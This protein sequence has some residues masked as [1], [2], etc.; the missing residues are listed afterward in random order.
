VASEVYLQYSTDLATWYDVGAAA[1]WNYA[2]GQATSGDTLTT[3]KL[4]TGVTRGKYHESAEL[5][6]AW[7]A[8]SVQEVDFA[9][10]PVE[11]NVLR[12]ILYYFRMQ[13]NDLDVYTLHP[14]DTYPSIKLP[15]SV[16]HT[17][18]LADGFKLADTILSKTIYHNIWSDGFDPVSPSWGTACFL[19]AAAVW[20]KS[21]FLTAEAAWGKSC[22]DTAG[23][24]WTDG[25]ASNV[26]S[27]AFDKSCW[28]TAGPVWDNRLP[29]DV[30][31]AA[32][33]ASL[34]TAAQ[35]ATPSMVSKVESATWGTSCFLTAAA[36]WSKSN[37]ATAAPT[38]VK[39]ANLAVS[40]V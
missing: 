33:G 37:W 32:W 27:A 29:T 36:A 30:E 15:V 10:V 17:L 2:N 35:I 12:D 6:E 39:D 25:L 31:S 11:A 38:W 40:G 3:N 1:H 4:S 13:G 24:T 22:W 18:S 26:E 28:L 9:I 5:A 23:P 7:T 34:L 19:T 14:G 16:A 8:G 21:C 20:G